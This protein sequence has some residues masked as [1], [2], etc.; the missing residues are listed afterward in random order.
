MPARRTAAIALIGVIAAGCASAPLASPGASGGSSP[1]APGRTAGSSALPTVAP[2]PTSRPLALLGAMPSASLDTATATKLQGVLDTLVTSGAPDAIAAVITRDG[3]WA[4]AA[5]IDG[6]NGQKAQPTDE[7]G[8]ASV[9]KP[10]LAA[11]VLRL[12]EQGKLDLD[13]PLGGYLGSDAALAN[14]A[15][16]RQALAM[17]G[18]IGE[19]SAAAQDAALAQCAHVQSRAEVLGGVPAPNSAPGKGYLYSNPTYKLLGYAVE[20]VTG[21]ALAD[22]YAS[23]V[24]GGLGGRILLQAPGH[25]TPQPWALPLAGHGGALDIA[26]YG[27]GGTLPCLGWSSFAIASSIA[28]DAPTLAAWAWHLFAGDVIGAASLGQMTTTNGG[29]GLGI[30][31]LPGYGAD[32]AYGY[33]G[34]QVGYAAF[35]SVLPERGIVAV[36]FI[37]DSESN[38]EG[39]IRQLIRAVQ[40]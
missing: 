39:Y 33:H 40:G 24:F 13:A 23:N 9:T 30:D 8:I 6:P 32:I 17:R 4:G 19:S 26:T 10:I 5:G 18:G 31:L 36:L 29:H 27:T 22:A 3:A 25:L 34:G 11:L 1:I 12:A 7:F 21:Q 2:S 15:T 38:V 14:G 20:Q 28:S 16:V 35:L 37:N